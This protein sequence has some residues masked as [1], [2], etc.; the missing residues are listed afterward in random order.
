[1]GCLLSSP[2]SRAPWLTQGPTPLAFTLKQP[3]LSEA[4]LVQEQFAVVTS[5]YV[6]WLFYSQNESVWKKPKNGN[7]GC[8][9]CGKPQANPASK[10]EECC[11]IQKKE[12]EG[13]SREGCFQGKSVAGKREFRVRRVLVGRVAGVAD[14]LQE[15]QCTSFL[16]GPLVDHS[17]LLMI[18]FLLFL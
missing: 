16:L 17:F 18:L 7:S 5:K 13:G 14:F 12:Q 8:V 4:N 1:M 11:F 15:L 2:V 9:Y 6:D 3:T 10:G